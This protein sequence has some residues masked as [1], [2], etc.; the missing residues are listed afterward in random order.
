[1]FLD[2]IEFEPFVVQVA[3]LDRIAMSCTIDL[4]NSNFLWYPRF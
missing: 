2:K 3:I 1:M 4:L